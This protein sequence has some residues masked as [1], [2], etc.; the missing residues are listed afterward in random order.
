MG[1]IFKQGSYYIDYRFRGKR[2]REKCGSSK[3]QAEQALAVRKA[4]IVQG[5]FRFAPQSRMPFS[6]FA[7]VYMKH[8]RANKRSW[9]RD[10]TLL[11]KLKPH[12]GPCRLD[13]VTS[14]MIEGYK[15]T[16]A[17]QV[18]PATVNREIALL[19]HMYNLA[20]EWGLAAEN[21]MRG[22]RLLREDNIQE[23]ILTR[24][25]IAQLLN[26]C[27]EYSRPIVL[28]ALHT[29]MRRGEILGLKWSQVDLEAGAITILQSKN[30]R[31]RKIPINDILKAALLELKRTATQE[32][33]FVSNKTKAPIGK[34]QTAWLTAIRK[35]GIIRCR[36]HDLR[37]T[38]AS[39]LVAAG[40]DL[41]TVKE[42]LGHSDIK[43]TSRYAH[44]APEV[45]V[46]AVSI[47]AD[48]LM[49]KVD[50]KWT[51]NDIGNNRPVQQF[52]DR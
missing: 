26:S 46:K 23:R 35:S 9:E 52:V 51:P 27:T 6:D 37:H 30:G 33:V 44:S 42:L 43:M 3:R 1:I 49:G 39:Y 28:T 19:K 36:F 25:E 12:F 48:S 5:K 50:T 7:E 18:K 17:S 24:T 14:F 11:N 32:H 13:Q 2:I 31:V 10:L 34:F 22:V 16:R 38:F 21:P 40:T 41:V 4:E 15:Q 8:S 47:L 45:K 29:G 20:V